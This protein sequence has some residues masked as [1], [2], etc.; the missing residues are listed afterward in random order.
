M[1]LAMLKSGF[2]LV[3]V[4]DVF[5]SLRRREQIHSSL[6]DVMAVIRHL[7]LGQDHAILTTLYQLA[8][9]GKLIDLFKQDVAL[10]V[11]IGVHVVLSF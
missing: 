11:L 7:A 5:G 6:E 1:I 2:R 8:S 10:L 3:F 9:S 4:Y